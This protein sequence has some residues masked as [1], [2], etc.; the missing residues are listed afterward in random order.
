MLRWAEREEER[1]ARFS[2]QRMATSAHMGLGEKGVDCGALSVCFQSGE[3][4][5]GADGFTD[6]ERVGAGRRVAVYGDQPLAGRHDQQAE[7]NVF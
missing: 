6:T 1:T 5:G 4:P 7:I 2:P 3:S